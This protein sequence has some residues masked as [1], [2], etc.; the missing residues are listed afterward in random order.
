ML[1]LGLF[2]MPATAPERMLADTLDWNL[3]ILRRA[4]H[5]GY[6]EAWIGQHFTT[7]WEPIV[8]P[9]QI[10]ARALAETARLRLGT[11]VEVLYTS[12]PVRL[13]LELAQLDH[14]AR[15]RLMFGFGSGGTPTDFQLYGVDPR[16]DQHQAM[17]REALRIML[18]CW[19]PGGPDAF[20][21]K[22]WRVHKPAY[23]DR[24]RW[25]VQPYAPIEPRIAFAG[26]MPRSGSMAI[27]G[28]R[29]YIPMSFHVAPEHL[30]I[31]WQTVEQGAASA[32]RVADR[33]RW[34]QIRDIYVADTDEQ[35]HRGAI[36]GF[37]GRFWNEHFALIAER[38]NILE[39][40]QRGTPPAAGERVDARYCVEHGTWFVGTPERVAAQIVEQYR[41]TGGFGTLLQIG[42]DYADAAARDGWLRSMELLATAVM[43]RVNAQL[44]R[45]SRN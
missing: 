11:G 36:D 6:D 45:N 28:E 25:H 26:F 16:A 27:A 40:F 34:R 41:L 12:H 39:L 22:F 2:L 33:T 19:K 21:G 15:G 35:A 43:P 9:Q 20:E 1:K 32:G 18:D 30:G 17:S 8:S 10:I 31:H 38:L 3:E 29:G 5:Y 24:Y 4:E 13:A 37:M 7:P 42:Y 23:S 44:A 14:L